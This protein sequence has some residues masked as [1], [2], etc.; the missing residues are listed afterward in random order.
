M[1]RHELRPDEIAYLASERRLGRL[2]TA[3]PTGR[4]QVT[5]VGMWRFN[6]ELGT[7]DISGHDLAATRKYRN[8]TLNPQAAFVVDDVAPGQGWH[9][10]AVMIEGPAHTVAPGPDGGAL[11]RVTPDRVVSWG[12]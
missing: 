12:L 6:P 10:R 11:I 4:P 2:A 8:V 5:P 1:R 7:I 9:P 3:D